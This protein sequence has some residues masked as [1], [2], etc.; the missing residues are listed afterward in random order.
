MPAALRDADLVIC[1]TGALHFVLTPALMAEAMHGRSHRPLFLIDI[2][3]PRDVDPSVTAI[4]GVFL[5]DIDKL[6]ETIDIT[7]E[8]RQK[9]IPLV[10]QIIDA[11][12]MHFQHW[13]R[14]NATVPTVASLTRKAERCAKPSSIASSPAAPNWTSANGRSSRD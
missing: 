8:H 13:F 4:P 10:Q 5:T 7:L 2:A 6:S 1:S 12:V 9:A 3:V 11:H 14:S